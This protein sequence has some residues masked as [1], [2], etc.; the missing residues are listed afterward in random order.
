MAEERVAAAA[1]NDERNVTIA[2]WKEWN[3]ATTATLRES[4]F[5]LPR[6]GGLSQES[7]EREFLDSFPRFCRRLECRAI[8]G[9]VIYG[10]AICVIL[11][12]RSCSRWRV[13]QGSGTFRS[14][15]K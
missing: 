15:E 12:Y 1:L 5:Y 10:H 7:S 2:S 11:N 4:E 6:V 9:I 14:P 8:L 13:F 3:C